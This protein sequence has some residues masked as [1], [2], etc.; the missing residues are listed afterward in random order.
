MTKLTA[1]STAGNYKWGVT[2]NVTDEQLLVFANAG[3]LQFYQRSPQSNAERV[4]AQAAGLWDN[5]KRPEKFERKSIPFSDEGVKLMVAE[6]EKE[7][8]IAKDVKIKASATAEF[9]EIGAAG[10]PKFRDER[11]VVARHI[12]EGDFVQ[13]AKTKVGMPCT[14][15]DSDKVEFLQAVKALIAKVKA[16]V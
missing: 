9:H 11:E 6:L 4:M 12:K 1:T 5:G 16:G 10:A 8:E 15:E 7:V 13:W 3:L 14:V 2:A